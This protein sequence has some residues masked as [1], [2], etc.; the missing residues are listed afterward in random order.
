MENQASYIAGYLL[1][2][3]IEDEEYNYKPW[4]LS[5]SK[6]SEISKYEGKAFAVSCGKVIGVMSYSDEDKI[7]VGGLYV[8]PG[9]KE[10]LVKRVLLKEVFYRKPCKEVEIVYRDELADEL[11][12]EL[13]TAKKKTGQYESSEE[14]IRSDS[15]TFR[16]LDQEACLSCRQMQEIAGLIY[17][18]DRY[19]YQEMFGSRQNAVKVISVL[20]ADNADKMFRLSNLYVAVMEEEIIG[21]ILWIRGNLQWNPA[22]LQDSL[23]KLGI[24]SAEHLDEVHSQYL[25]RYDL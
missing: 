23:K 11:L 24:G 5:R 22:V 9:C 16:Q 14:N 25:T 15:I 7:F 21:M 12:E 3:V 8:K 20:L 19:I 13:K 17:D 4:W 18:T 2:G 6:W 1:F 10:K